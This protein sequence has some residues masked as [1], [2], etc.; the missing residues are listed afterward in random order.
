VQE[1]I[2]PSLADLNPFPPVL[3]VLR[4]RNN[5][6]TLISSALLFAF[7]C[8]IPYTCS[9]TLTDAYDY[10]ALET[11]L[12][13]LSFGAGSML[14]SVLGGRWSDRE[15]RR[16]THANGGHHS[17]EMRLESTKP[18]AVV[19]P[20]SCIAYAWLAQKHV[21]VSTLCISLFFSGFFSM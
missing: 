13:L 4:R 19:L 5:I 9:R 12:V 21:H 20:L 1:K 3:L 17:P 2:A 8:C 10:D 18:A 14:G 16:L 11:G 15:L 6:P 7:D